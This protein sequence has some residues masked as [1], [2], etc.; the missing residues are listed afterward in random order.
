MG[1]DAH[2]HTHT[3]TMSLL[4]TL[5]RE[6]WWPFLPTCNMACVMQYGAKKFFRKEWTVRSSTDLGSCLYISAVAAY[7]AGVCMKFVFRDSLCPWSSAPALEAPV[8]CS[9][10]GCCRSHVAPCEALA[11][12]GG[13]RVPLVSAVQAS[14]GCSVKLCGWKC[15]TAS[16]L[17]YTPSLTDC[18][19]HP[20]Q[21][22]K[23]MPLYYRSH[24]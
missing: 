11:A 15:L 18:L 5:A 13:R 4:S 22:S 19:S 7:V 3:S 23:H 12:A 16:L 17:P 8:L 6:L 9:A 24:F 20:L 14:T 2:T 10:V 1:V 21:L